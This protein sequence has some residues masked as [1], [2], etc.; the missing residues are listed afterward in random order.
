MT[1]LAEELGGNAGQ[2]AVMHT[3]RLIFIVA[4]IPSLISVITGL[5]S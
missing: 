2:V 5:V 3:V 1:L 4:I